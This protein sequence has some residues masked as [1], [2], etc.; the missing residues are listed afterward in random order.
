MRQGDGSEILGPDDPRTMVIGIIHVTPGDDRQSVLIAISTQEKLGRDQIVLDLPAQNKAFKNAVDFEGLHQMA[1]EIEATLV[2]VI[3]E[4]SKIA[5]YARK[6]RFQVYP[7]L[8]ELT[9]AEFPPLEPEEEALATPVEDDPSDHATTFPIIPPTPSAASTSTSPATPKLESTPGQPPTS[10][11]NQPAPI[12]FPAT[13]ADEEG[14]LPLVED[15]GHTAPLVDEDE[16]PTDPSLKSAPSPLAGTAATAAAASATGSAA[17]QNATIDTAHTPDSTTPQA[18]TIDAANT[19][20]AT[21]IDATGGLPAVAAGSAGA[22]VPSGAQPPNFY[23]EPS[24]PPRHRSWRGL[25]LTAL[26]VVLLIALLAAFNRPILDLFFPPTATVTI[27][28]D[29]QQ[30]LHTYQLTAVLGVPDPSKDQVDARA[31][32]AISQPQSSTVKATGQGS[33]PGRQAQGTLTF[34]NPLPSSLM[35]QAGTAIFDPHNSNIVVVNDDTITL[36][37]FDPSQGSQGLQGVQDNAH[38]VNIGSDQ[39][40]PQDELKGPVGS[41]GAYVNNTAFQGGQDAQTYSY[42]QQSD[43]DNAAQALESTLNGQTMQLLQTQARQNERAVGQPHCAPQVQSSGVAGTQVSTV[44][45]TVAMNCLGEVY[46]MQA[47]QALATHKLMQAASVNPGPTYAPVGNLAAQVTRATPANH[48]DVQLTVNALGV[49]AYQF[50]NA[51]RASLAR[52]I[53]GKSSQDARALLLHQPGVHN[54]IITLTGVGV[55]TVP[56]DVTSITLHVEGI[57]GLHA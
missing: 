32:Y 30:L 29:S 15:E 16:A 17:S 2:L 56:D 57:Q 45:V 5:N 55:T 34:Y 23:Y 1:S 19:P 33:I 54:A 43:I 3:P 36:P 26:I 49:W 6:E 20:P 40:I 4:R 41:S 22:L 8:D 27:T 14:T 11:Q 42:V 48:G 44:T 46:D 52:L 10:S 53:V 37:A 18:T 47:V 38:T 31:V 28:P 39:N 13:P 24:E 51:Q 35:I 9:A 7:S 25:L 50:S 12:V 21:T